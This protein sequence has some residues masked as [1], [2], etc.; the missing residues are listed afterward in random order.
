MKLIVKICAI[1][2]FAQGIS[3]SQSLDLN[4]LKLAQKFSKSQ[5]PI[6]SVAKREK[7]QDYF[8]A[9]KILDSDLYIVG[10]GDLLHINI[11]ASNETFD[12]SIAISP[13][14]KLLI[15]SV[16]IVNCEELTLSQLIEDIT[17]QIKSWNSSVKVNVELEQIREFRVLVVGQ[18]SNAGYFIV[19]PMTRFSDLFNQIISD[20]NQRYKDSM[21]EEQNKDFYETSGMRSRIAVDD[22]YNRKLGLDKETYHDIDHLS[23]RNIELIRNNDTT[24]IDIEKF[25]VTGDYNY[26]PYIHQDDIIRIPYKSQFFTIQGGVQK[27]GRYEYNASD[28]LADALAIAGGNRPN[29]KLDSIRVT[30]SN[31]INNS[32]SFFLTYEKSKS[33]KMLSEDHIMIPLFY[34]KEPHHIVEIIG[35]ISHPGSYPIEFGKT[36]INEIIMVAGG[37]LPTAD[38]SRIF[39]NN[40]E[41]AN[42]PD[43]ELER[44][45]LKAEPYRSI[46]EQAYVKARLRTEKGAL[47]TSLNNIKHKDHLVSNKDII[48]I[49]RHFP[50]VEVIGAVLSPGRY[51]FKAEKKSNSYITAAGGVAKNASKKRFLIKGTT[52][53]RLKLNRKNKLEPGD[54]IFIPDKVDYNEWIAAKELVGALYQSGLLIYYIQ[55]IIRNLNN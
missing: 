51:P 52:G 37:F 24:I 17:K 47:E 48:Y 20:Y 33:T 43:R 1:F 28:N 13:S 39:I 26:N 6:N 3:K 14:G 30:R 45:L 55:T 29:A 54:I 53:Q 49:P 36:S 27:P 41:I 34:K 19:T 11:I 32:E 25:K 7:N 21:R 38:T 10:P 5:S 31:K 4:A 2:I 12:H 50:Y 46:E 15:P 40:S 18:F 16:G 35:E 8:I 44:I 22:F 42:I 9:D 23:K